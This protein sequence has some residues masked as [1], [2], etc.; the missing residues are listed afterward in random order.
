MAA[1]A[2]GEEMQEEEGTGL[3]A[4]YAVPQPPSGLEAA[5]YERPATGL[6]LTAAK[7][8]K[9]MAYGGMSRLCSTQGE[10]FRSI[11]EMHKQR[12][13]GLN[14]S[15]EDQLEYARKGFSPWWVGKGKCLP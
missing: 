6:V 13:R 14:S 9:I 5:E 3:P 7:H 1:A 10:A 8:R 12:A 15:F 4:I 2:V 11:M